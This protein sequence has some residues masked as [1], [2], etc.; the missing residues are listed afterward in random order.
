MKRIISAAMLAGAF[1]AGYAQ[2]A[3][4]HY[5]AT[6]AQDGSG[7][8]TSVQE[9]IS[10][11]PEN[12]KEPWCIFVKNGSYREQVTVPKNK[13]HIHLIGQ[14]KNNTVIHH[15]LNVGGRPK[16][17]EDTS[18]AE[19]WQHSVHNPNSEVAGFEGSVVKVEGNHFY[20]ENISYVNDWGTKS[21]KGPQA[22]AM[23]LRGDCAAFYNCIF[24]SFQDTW[25]T[26]KDD[27]HRL[28]AKDCRIEGAVDYFYGGGD[29]L[30][31]NCTFYNTRSG[32]VI[33]A[34]CHK[35]AKFGYVFRN[36]IV[37]GNEAAAD[38][39]QKLGRPWHNSPITV[40]INT[41]M[42]IPVAPEGWTNMGTIPGLFAEYNSR[43]TEG[44]MLDLSCRKTEYEGRGDEAGKGSCRASITKDEAD[45]LT[46]E[47]IIMR[48]D[49]WNP[50]A[51]M[52]K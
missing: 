19:Y 18:K 21:Q 28:Y 20:S 11:A 4:Q 25:M 37:D 34:P 3:A 10:A 42:R 32:S 39:R 6:V 51:F 17:G 33:V 47:R 48:N 8:Y 43:D 36:C 38:G 9:A 26:S 23:M 1:L 16:E 30:L 22:L 35:N 40:Y 12:R 44:N 29:A 46:Y 50:R 49:G 45:K 24:R 15:N 13:P 41:T 31:E 2:K 5:H 14:D 52:N 7:N 27:S